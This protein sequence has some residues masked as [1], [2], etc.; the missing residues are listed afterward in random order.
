MPGENGQQICK[1]G[2]ALLASLV[3]EHVIPPGLG[4][5]FACQQVGLGSNLP[6]FDHRFLGRI[7][8]SIPSRRHVQPCKLDSRPDLGID[9]VFQTSI[10]EKN[11]RNFA[12]LGKLNR[13]PSLHVSSQYKQT[14]KGKQ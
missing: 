12:E 14:D 10:S 7:M 3:P 6:E 8:V 13:A 4:P 2:R 1:C 5:L 11:C 9:A